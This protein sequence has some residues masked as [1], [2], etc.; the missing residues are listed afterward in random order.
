[1]AVNQID[2]IAENRFGGGGQGAALVVIAPTV[3]MFPVGGVGIKGVFG[4][5][6]GD[7]GTRPSQEL[8][9]GRGERVWNGGH[10]YLVEYSSLHID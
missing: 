10:G 9:D 8:L 4:V 7:V 6:M 2:D 5:T 1:M 3:E